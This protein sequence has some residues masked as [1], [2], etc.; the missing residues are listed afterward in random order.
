MSIINDETNYIQYI[1]S[2]VIDPIVF[3]E[4]GYML[5][6]VRNETYID[7]IENTPLP[8]Q[9]QHVMQRIV[10]AAVHLLGSKQDIVH[11]T[12]RL[13]EDREEWDLAVMDGHGS[14]TEKNPYT[15]NYH[16]HN[17]ALL[18]IMEMITNGDL[19]EIMSRD[20]NSEED[21][22][23]ALQKAL[24]RK[25]VEFKKDMTH[26]GTTF[27]L[28]QIRH[29][30]TT[31]KITVN[32][33]TVGD[34]PVTIYSNGEK[35]LES[36]QHT[37]SNNDELE[38]LRRENRIDRS[39]E[40]TLSSSFKFLDERTVVSEPAYY[41]NVLYCPLAMTQS[42]GHIQYKQGGTKVVD[43][44][45]LFGLAP[46]KATMIFDETDELVIKGYSDGVSDVV[47]EYL[48]E[49]AVLLKTSN[50][51]QTA[52][53]AKMKWE[54]TWDCVNKVVYEKAIKDGLTLAD[55]PKKTFHFGKGA[56]DVCCVSWIQRMNGRV[57]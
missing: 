8:P 39:E 23:T 30:F 31:K 44:M 46:F 3:A 57:I 14:S 10:D 29:D 52:D 16:R 32:V 27:S 4:I 24:C 13:F 19:D 25:C 55:V 20:I 43:E 2:P 48:P 22:A 15:G 33:L 53:Y 41:V 37:W 47:V 42:I 36:I 5:S 34:S 12:H 26:I 38:R 56:D 9:S 45:G 49:D 28:I 35:V 51:T 40:L 18:V 17:L 11:T 7:T 54:K 50:A 1:N 6:E 21:P